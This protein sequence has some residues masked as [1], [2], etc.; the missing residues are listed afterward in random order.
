MPQNVLITCPNCK[1]RFTATLYN[2]V[3]AK[4]NP[5]L[6]ELLIRGR[7]NLVICPS[8][9]TSGAVN[10]PVLYFNP[11]KEQALIYLP[12]EIG[13]N[14]LERQRII[15]DLTNRLL[16]SLPPEE[17]KAYIFQP[18]VFITRKSF[19]EEILKAEGISFEE[20]MAQEL[21]LGLLEAL[22]SSPEEKWKEILENNAP[23]LD[24][25][26]FR[27][28]GGFIRETSS[29]GQKELSA[30]LTRLQEKIGDF[31][32]AK[33]RETRRALME[34]MLKSGDE[35]LEAIVAQTRPLIDYKFYQI[36]AERIDEEEAEGKAKE[37]QKLRELRDKVLDITARQ[38]AEARAALD[39]ATRLLKEIWESEDRQ[40][41]LREKADEIDMTFL[42]LLS[43]NLQWA[44]IQGDEEMAKE[45][46]SLADIAVDIMREKA[47]PQ[48]RLINELMDASY[49]E[50]TRRLLEENAPLVDQELVEL[51]G[52]L[53]HDL[54]EQ[55][56]LEA[57]RH[58]AEVQRQAQAM[59]T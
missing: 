15:G 13:G 6:K 22:L 2:I 5:V 48:L 55:G 19:I 8:C 44:Q 10:A 25:L 54:D 50:E 57:A 52:A 42:S 37:A 49:P 41:S 39:K 3:D 1:Q 35:E 58:L 30:Q 40:K 9:G 17:K 18:K 43:A 20:I 26:F 12:T 32:A 23:L 16:K 14:D 34:T 59:V 45:L 11:D 53:V 33:E 31:L 46:A 47:P 27:I 4:R 29:Q 28:L 36:M 24:P 56:Y 7:L 21:R 38:D 51:M